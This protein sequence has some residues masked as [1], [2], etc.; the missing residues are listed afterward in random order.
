MTPGGNMD[1]RKERRVLEMVVVEI[2]IKT[3]F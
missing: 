3:N 1:I 2:N